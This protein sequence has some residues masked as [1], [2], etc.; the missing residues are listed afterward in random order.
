MGCLALDDG[1]KR[2]GGRAYGTGE[3]ARNAQRF[4]DVRYGMC[5]VL[6]S[7]YDFVSLR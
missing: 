5:A 3:G 6:D 7:R 4:C 1:V 2:V